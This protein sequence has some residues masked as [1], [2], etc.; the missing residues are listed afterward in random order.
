[1]LV[2]V[3]DPVTSSV[4]LSINGATWGGT[5][6]AYVTATRTVPG[7]AAVLV[8][9][10]IQKPLV[11]GYLVAVD[12]EMPLASQVTYQVTG[13]SAAGA[14]V[15]TASA[16]VSTVGGSVGVWVKA[17]GR[18]DLSVLCQLADSPTLSSPTIGGTYQVIGGDAV[19]V[20]Q[21]SGVAA[22]SGQLVLRTDAGAQ[23]AALRE[24]FRTARVVLLQPVGESDLEPDWYYVGSVTPVNP[25]GFVGFGFRRWQVDVTRVRVPAGQQGGSTWTYGS[26]MATF[27]TYADLKAAYPSYFAMAQGPA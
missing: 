5:V 24:L 15:A 10:V 21:W 6:P 4:R 23:T 12:H 20:S 14:V 11:G 19:A 27:A 9:G 1:V 3:F 22:D 13:Y 7:S 18:P 26:V 17:P 2:A 25:G 8:R 16:T